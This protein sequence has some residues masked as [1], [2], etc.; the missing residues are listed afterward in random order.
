MCSLCVWKSDRLR[1]ESG[2]LQGELWQ[3]LVT[4]GLSGG[5]FC[6]KVL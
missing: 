2:C 4:S 1:V 3:C 5:K 6:E